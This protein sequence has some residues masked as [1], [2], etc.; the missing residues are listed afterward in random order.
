MAKVIRTAGPPKPKMPVQRI[1]Y[2]RNRYLGLQGSAL[3]PEWEKRPTMK[4]LWQLEERDPLTGKRLYFED[5]VSLKLG[6]SAKLLSI[7]DAL[8]NGNANIQPG[9]V[10]E[11]DDLIGLSCQASFVNKAPD[12]KG[13]V[14]PRID[15]Y[16]PLAANMEP[17]VLELESLPPLEKE[18]PNTV[19]QAV[20]AS[21]QP[22]NGKLPEPAAP[23]APASPALAAADPTSWH[24]PKRDNSTTTAGGK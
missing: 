13:Y 3:H 21:S 22:T 17:L 19:K 12:K 18:E 14:W 6:D 15:K 7:T 8:C 10:L 2:A 9:Q 16:F 1:L 4:V 5:L 11:T 20:I 24:I 23:P